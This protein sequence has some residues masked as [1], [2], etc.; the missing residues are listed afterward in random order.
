MEIKSNNFFFQIMLFVI[1]IFFSTYIGNKKKYA[2]LTDTKINKYQKYVNILVKEINDE[3]KSVST[4][5]QSL[6]FYYF[7]G[8]KIKIKIKDT[9]KKFKDI[10][11]EKY[12]S[13]LK[14]KDANNISKAH[15][16]LLT[17]NCQR[18]PNINSGN[19]CPINHSMIVLT[20]YRET[21]NNISGDIMNFIGKIEDEHFIRESSKIIFKKKI[22]SKNSEVIFEKYFLGNIDVKG[23]SRHNNYLNKEPFYSSEYLKKKCA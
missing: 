6:R 1:V 12:K 18:S 15:G 17:L 4:T 2:F 10:I 14:I 23:K 9:C 13:K 16:P 11:L 19:N 5:G 22:Y 7:K 8:D 3:Y 21:Y 20:Y